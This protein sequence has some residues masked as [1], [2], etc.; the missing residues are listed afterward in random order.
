[1]NDAEMPAGPPRTDAREIR[2]RWPGLVWAV[3]LAAAMVVA[4]LALTAV[5][6]RGVNIVVVFDKAAGARAGET[7]VI[8]KGVR[9]GRVVKIAVSRDARHVEMTLRMA[10]ETRDALRDGARFWLIGASPSLMDLSSLQAVV[11]GVSIGASPGT[12][13]PRRR[14]VGLTAPPPVPADVVGTPYV[15]EGAFGSTRPGA[16]VYYHG[17][18]VGKVTRIALRQPDRFQLS[19]FVTA[20]YDRLVTSGSRFFSTKALEIK[21]D[22]SGITGEL[23]PG[24]SP[25]TGGVEFETPEPYSGAPQSPAGT[26]FPVYPDAARAE[27]APSGRAVRYQAR[28][29]K[30]G[31]VLR[32]GAPVV[33]AGFPIGRVVDH[34]LA[35]DPLGAD[36]SGMV[37]LEIEPATL[38]LS[39]A[40]EEADRRRRTD[41]LLLGLVRHGYRLQLAQNPPLIGATGLELRQVLRP[42]AYAP[43]PVGQVTALPT[44]ETASFGDLS[45]KANAAL[46][47]LDAVPIEQI[48]QDVRRVTK[49]L[50][51]LVSSPEVRDGLKHLDSTLAGLDEITAAA[52]PKVGP[53]VDKL[54]AAADQMQVLAGSANKIVS[55]EG[56]SQD[57]NLPDAIRQLTEAARSLRSLADYLDRHPEAVLKGKRPGS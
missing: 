14:F 40:G 9:V 27:S 43:A 25:L 28:F 51:V 24:S 42:A 50:S 31:G 41:Q 16:G 52:K 1:M 48:G 56:A 38:G 15:L 39:V 20:P 4:Y 26:L 45:E 2:T 47:A 3:P 54:T 29:H 21:L 33:L 6:N 23:G 32:D 35:A 53:L 37:T 13:A 11:S 34:R 22:G 49:Q 12:G 17:L 57:A 36:V 5:S 46:G 7:P 18:E 55:G 30:A 44:A 19:I 10:P 8:Y